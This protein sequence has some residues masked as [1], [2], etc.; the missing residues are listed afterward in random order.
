[1]RPKTEY[2]KT[3]GINIAY[4]VIGEGSVDLLFVIGGPSNIDV[5][6]EEPR[7]A[8]FLTRLASFRG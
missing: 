5:V 8:R 7:Y 4:Q 1:V 3:S 6:W 2:A